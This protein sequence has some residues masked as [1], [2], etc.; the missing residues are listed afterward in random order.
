MCAQHGGQSAPTN[1]AATEKTKG[2]FESAISKGHTTAVQSAIPFLHE[3]CNYFLTYDHGGQPFT[4]TSELERRSRDTGWAFH[5]TSTEKTTNAK[6]SYSKIQEK[7]LCT[8]TVTRRSRLWKFQAVKASAT[9]AKKARNDYATQSSAL[10]NMSEAGSTTP[11]I[12]LKS[13]CALRT[14]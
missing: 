2:L 9:K 7:R 8:E 5:N 14:N 10:K 13:S 6:S 12:S 4:K 1:Q 3:K 11:P